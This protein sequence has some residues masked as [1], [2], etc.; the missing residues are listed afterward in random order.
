MK[1][2]THFA[3]RIDKLDEAGEIHEH[4]AGIEDVQLADSVYRAARKR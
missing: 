2:R 1:T 3:H 4:L